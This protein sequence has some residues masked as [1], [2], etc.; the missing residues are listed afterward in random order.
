MF[1]S[2]LK[3]PSATQH[4]E[5]MHAQNCVEQDPKPPRRRSP[6]HYG[7]DNILARQA[8]RGEHLRMFFFCMGHSFCMRTSDLFGFLRPIGAKMQAL[9][10]LHLNLP[11]SKQRVVATLCWSFSRHQGCWGGVVE[12]VLSCEPKQNLTTL[13]Q[14][15]G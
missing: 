8:E 6:V 7:T 3:A 12:W 14:C 5:P 9:P 4:H 11:R 13:A 1:A 10:I 2:C 15:F